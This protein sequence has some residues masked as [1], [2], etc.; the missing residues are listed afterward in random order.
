[1]ALVQTYSSDEED[2]AALSVADVF[3]VSSLAASKKPRL[4]V[5]HD[6]ALF[7]VPAPDVLAEVYKLAENST[8]TRAELRAAGSTQPGVVGY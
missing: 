2:V 7:S 3:G 6:P 8:S 4:Q 5:D 1:M